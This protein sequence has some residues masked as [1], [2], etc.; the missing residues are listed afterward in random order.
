MRP[1]TGRENPVTALSKPF[2]P[3]A[4]LPVGVFDELAQAQTGG[5]FFPLEPRTRDQ[6][7]RLIVFRLARSSFS[8]Q[9]KP[10]D[11]RGCDRHLGRCHLVFFRLLPAAHRHPANA[12]N[13]AGAHPRDA[14][15]R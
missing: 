12:W 3:L 1:D 6:L 4:A 2:M 11:D 9:S 15:R 10:L 8:S 7:I 14:R 5:H 13:A